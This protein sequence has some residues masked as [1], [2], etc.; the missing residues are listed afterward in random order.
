MNSGKCMINEDEPKW[1]IPVTGKQV[2][3]WLDRLNEFGFKLARNA[4][5]VGAFWYTAISMTDY[6]VT[7]AAAVLTLIFA[8]HTTWSCASFHVLN[9]EAGKSK[10]SRFMLAK[11]DFLIGIALYGSILLAVVA[12][13]SRTASHV[14]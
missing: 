4:A 5:I 13:V 8:V 11:L 2:P 1:Y 6:F 14:P 12:F 3:A 10:F 7:L 9:S